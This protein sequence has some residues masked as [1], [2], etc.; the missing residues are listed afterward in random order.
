MHLTS[1]RSGWRFQIRIPRD[2]DGLFGLSPPR[3]NIG[4]IG[5]RYASAPPVYWRVM[6]SLYSSLVLQPRL[7]S[8]ARYAARVLPQG[9]EFQ[10]TVF[11]Q[12]EAIAKDDR[13]LSAIGALVATELSALA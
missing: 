8:P 2:L 10:L 6:P 7:L 3:L 5:R 13:F 4:P 11:A 1:R 9:Q 12:G